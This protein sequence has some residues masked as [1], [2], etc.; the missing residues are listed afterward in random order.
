MV[1][2]LQNEWTV[3][4]RNIRHISLVSV[5]VILSACTS[6]TIFPPGSS[7]EDPIYKDYMDGKFDSAGH[8]FG[9]RVWQA[10]TD[11]DPATGEV[12]AEGWGVI[13]GVHE[14]GSLCQ[15]SD[16]E[17]GPGPFSL[18]VRLLSPEVPLP[19]EL[20]EGAEPEKILLLR[21]VDQE[22]SEIA[23]RSLTRKELRKA[24]TY[25][26]FW[27]DLNRYSMPIIYKGKMRIELIWTGN[28]PLRID[29]LELFRTQSRVVIDPPSRF[30]S[31][32]DTLRLELLNTPDDWELDLQCDQ[33]NL[34]ARLV[35]LLDGG[36]ATQVD[37][38]F[39]SII[40]A[41]LAS[42]VQGCQWPVHLTSKL[43]SSKSSYFDE[44]SRVTL[45]N[46]PI[47]CDFVGGEGKTK[48]L[49]TG[50][51]SFPA[52]KPLPEN[53]S[54]MAVLGFSAAQMDDIALMRVVLPVE[55]DSAPAIVAELIQRCQ[56]DV[57]IGFGEGTPQVDVEGVAFNIKGA[58]GIA[59]G[60]PDNRGNIYYETP[61]VE[62]GPA[63]LDTRL[64][65]GRISSSLVQ[66]GIPAQSGNDISRYVCN[67]VFYGIMH[68]VQQTEIIAGFIHVPSTSSFASLSPIE[69]Q[70]V[71]QTAIREAVSEV[72]SN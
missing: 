43:T 34:S 28:H 27:V 20:E 16:V 68:A 29:Y 47:P 31:A 17:L 48:V 12:Q 9:A 5:L 19:E 72:T 59:G 46:Q 22:N 52:K 2:G 71:L 69:A 32:E 8:P 13:P 41:P 62:G 58:T 35:D 23:S 42:I 6:E 51:E 25:Q 15:L 18:N 24:L 30:L 61:I 70:T 45:Y 55:Y 33:E 63:I 57:V 49:I 66:A 39:R 67:N 26:N 21:V 40:T 65:A 37:T 44:A 64:P 36:Q 53:A 56:P 50:F 7:S 11:C 14:S 1:C 3:D 4:M 54:A 38:E 10:E 60:L